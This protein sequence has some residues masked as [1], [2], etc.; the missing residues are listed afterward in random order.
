MN[1][2]ALRA[3]ARRKI[4]FQS[5]SSAKY[6]D[7]D[8]DANINEWYREAMSWIFLAM[9]IWEYGGDTVTTNLVSGQIEYVLPS[10]MVI[11]NRVEVLYP[12]QTDYVHAT[13]IDDKQVEGQAFAN[14]EI[15]TGSEGAPVYRL[16]DNSLFL[17]PAPSANVTNGLKVEIM[18]DITDLSAAGDVPNINPLLHKI[19]AIGAA[20]EYCITNGH[21]RKAAQLMKRLVGR[22]EGDSTGLK[23]QLETLV[24]SRDRSVKPRF[25][26]RRQ[27]FK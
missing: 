1:L 3:S 13:R 12:N 5:T 2:T 19:L 21:Q 20:Y 18:E 14:G 22:F 27:S 7:A 16:F 26:A 11:L 4:S 10:D 9:G 23:F 25:I 24:G 17:Y 8:L 6:L 15:S